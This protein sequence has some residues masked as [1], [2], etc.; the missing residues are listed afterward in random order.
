MLCGP[1]ILLLRMNEPRTP[2]PPAGVA[3]EGAMAISV[4]PGSH[5]ELK[6]R[7]GAHTVIWARGQKLVHE[8]QTSGGFWN[9]L[10]RAK[11]GQCFVLLDVTRSH[12]GAS[13]ADGT[14]P[15]PDVKKRLDA[16]LVALD[17]NNEDAVFA[18]RDLPRSTKYH[19]KIVQQLDCA[20]LALSDENLL[21]ET[22]GYTGQSWREINSRP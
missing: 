10:V 3:G 9:A 16:D 21:R 2:S 4:S 1:C 6:V 22:L 20:A 11:E 19:V 7:R 8:F 14:R 12:Y 15:L 17:W 13:L 18:R 5:V